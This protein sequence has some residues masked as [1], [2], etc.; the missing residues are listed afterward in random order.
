MREWQ[1]AGRIRFVGFS[2]HAMTSVI[3]KAIE[4]GEF[5]YVNLHYQFVGSYTATG[6]GSNG[7]GGN[8]DALV[9]AQKQDMGIFSYV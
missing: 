4:T 7:T 8:Y 3:V 9:A 2:T 1:K 6:S 5:D